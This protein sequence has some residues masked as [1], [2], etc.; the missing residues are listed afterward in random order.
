MNPDIPVFKSEADERSLKVLILQKA[1][2]IGPSVATIVES[3]WVEA[4]KNVLYDVDRF[5]KLAETY[6]STRLEAASRRALFHGHSNYYTVDYILNKNLDNL[7]LS[8]YV[9]IEGQY[10]FWAPKEQETK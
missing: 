8:H 1:E 2:S 6:S 5:L 3:M 10:L 9:D 7:P 4:V